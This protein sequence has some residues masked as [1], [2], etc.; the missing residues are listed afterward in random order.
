MFNISYRSGVP[1]K[2]FSSNKHLLD[3]QGNSTKDDTIIA[4][5]IVKD[6]IVS[7]GGIRNA[8]INKQILSSVKSADKDT[9]VI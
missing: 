7:V 6:D 1:E 2:G 4:L 8:S 9:T 3:I 5:R